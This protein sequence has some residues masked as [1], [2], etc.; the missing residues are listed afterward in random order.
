[1]I[2]IPV[3]RAERTIEFLGCSSW[4]LYAAS[5]DTSLKRKRSV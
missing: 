5:S 2:T 4:L 1:M 3:V